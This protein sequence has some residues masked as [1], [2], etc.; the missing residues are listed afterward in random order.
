MAILATIRSW[1]APAAVNQRPIRNAADSS[2]T[3][4]SP[5]DAGA[6][7]RRTMGWRAP[8]SSPNSAVLA[9]LATLRDRSRAAARNDG[10]AKGAIEALVSNLIG[11]GIKPLSQAPDD[12]VVEFRG[13]RMPFRQAVHALWLEWTDHSDADGRLDFYGQQ[14]QVARAWLEGG[15]CFARVRDRRP[16]DRLPVPMQVQVLEPELCPHTH[17]A[18]LPSG[19]RVRAGIE[20]DRIGREVAYWFHPIRPG[21]TQDFDASRLVRVTNDEFRPVAHVYDP[22]RPGQI[23]GI[24]H[25]TPALIALHEASK[26]ADAT[27]MRQQIANLFA[28]FVKRPAGIGDDPV[29]PLTGL[30]NTSGELPPMVGMEPGTIQELDVGEE[31]EFSDPPKVG[32]EFADFMRQILRGVAAATGVPYEVLTGDM[33]GLNDRTMR[34]VLNEFRRRIQAWQHQLIAY[35]FCR[36]IWNA[37]MDRV[38]ISGVL[39]IPASYVEDPRPWR[40]VKWMPPKWAYIHPV[41]DVL[42]QE[43]A[44][45]AGFISRS[46]VVAENG[47]DAEAIDAEQ[48]ADNDRADALGLRYDSDARYSRG[49]ATPDDPLDV[50]PSPQEAHA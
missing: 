48:K 37:W 31:I 4:G 5:Y 25:L 27:L 34:V 46:A 35:Q 13:R 28:G 49:G 43:R 23:R 9:N 15:D 44:I 47:E 42:A 6:H 21:D 17:H 36:P 24:P 14:A 1:F 18:L 40:A 10:F 33:T 20:F 29:N 7:T 30:P 16:E 39:Q 8:T 3:T 12:L 19:N 22:L 26:F 50:A 32:Q 45:R 11:T 2:T 38:F 41:Q